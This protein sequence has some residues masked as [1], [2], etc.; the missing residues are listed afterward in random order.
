MFWCGGAH[1]L[2]INYELHIQ[3]HPLPKCSLHPQDIFAWHITQEH[4]LSVIYTERMKKC[5]ICIFCDWRIPLRFVLLRESFY[6]LLRIANFIHITYLQIWRFS[7]SFTMQETEVCLLWFCW[8]WKGGKEITLVF[9]HKCFLTGHV[10]ALQGH[11][12]VISDVCKS[13]CHL[14]P[15]DPKQLRSQTCSSGHPVH[16]HFFRQIWWTAAAVKGYPDRG[17]SSALPP[18]PVHL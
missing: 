12:V 8:R 18:G 11:L 15:S 1:V 14:S 17:V 6:I 3:F 4:L 5:K 16:P 9:S 2:H 7:L 13:A 10:S